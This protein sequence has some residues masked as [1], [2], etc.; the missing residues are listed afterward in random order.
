MSHAPARDWSSLKR[1][2][3]S[4]FCSLLIASLLAF[5]STLNGNNSPIEVPPGYEYSHGD[6]FSGDELNLEMWGL[7]INE[8]NLQNERVDCVYKLENISVENGLMI[9]TQKREPKP[10][11]GKSW[12]KNI[13]FNYSSGGV[14]T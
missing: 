9:F 1:V 6:E 3:F 4:S 10:V 11:L 8:K 2:F 12:S 7:G 5:P 14:H 13:L